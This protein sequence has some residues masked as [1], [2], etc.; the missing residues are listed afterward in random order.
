V[1]ELNGVTLRAGVLRGQAAGAQPGERRSARNRVR[2]PKSHREGSFVRGRRTL[3]LLRYTLV[4][5]GCV[6]HRRLSY[7]ACLPCART[8]L[9]LGAAWSVW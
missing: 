1:P 7:A 3:S 4:E 2:V 9:L 8:R 5:T 6:D